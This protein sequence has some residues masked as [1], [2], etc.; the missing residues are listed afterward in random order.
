MSSTVQLDI[1]HL[2]LPPINLTADDVQ[3][4]FVT[5]KGSFQQEVTD[6]VTLF[7][8]VADFQQLHEV[9]GK[10]GHITII[11][12]G[13]L[14]SELACALGYKTKSTKGSVTQVYPEY[15]NMAKV[16]PEYL[17]RWTTDKVKSEGVDIITHSTVKDVT[18]TPDGKLKLS[19]DTGKEVGFIYT[20]SL[21]YTL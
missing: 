7:R 14:G 1:T 10:G 9:A 16:L 11:G 2:T 12:G 17:S 21:V 8:S 5:F 18:T 4:K 6:K 15:G 19:F 20:F 13:F 3:A